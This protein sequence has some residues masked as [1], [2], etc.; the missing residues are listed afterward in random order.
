M[1]TRFYSSS[2]HASADG[3]TVILL[4]GPVCCGK[5]TYARSLPGTLLLSCDALMQTLYPGGCG[6]QHDTLA[7]RARAYLFS[8]A[9]QLSAAGMT[10]VLDFG[11]WT[12][13]M[14]AEAIA[15]LPGCRLDWRCIAVPPAEWTRR[16]EKRNAA[17]L[18]GTGDP[19]DYYVDEGLL[20]KVNALFEPPTEEELPGLTVIEG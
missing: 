20:A 1:S 6:T 5:T 16:I 11:F 14:C 3:G 15:A 10:P 18:S 9:R 17:H 19:A 2:A 8:L 13:E 12:R 4:I 7:S